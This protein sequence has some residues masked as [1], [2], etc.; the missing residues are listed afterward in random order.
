VMNRQ[1]RNFRFRPWRRAKGLVCT[2]CGHYMRAADASAA[3]RL[4]IKEAVEGGSEHEECMDGVG[5]WVE[6]FNGSQLGYVLKKQKG[7]REGP[8]HLQ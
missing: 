2:P 5:K 4:K 7:A 1:Y 6:K 3:D 8:H